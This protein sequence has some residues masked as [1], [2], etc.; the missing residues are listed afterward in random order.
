MG[1]RHCHRLR[2]ERDRLRRRV[3]RLEREWDVGDPSDV[4]D[5]PDYDRDDLEDDRGAGPDDYPSGL[6]EYEPS[7]HGVGYHPAYERYRADTSVQVNRGLLAGEGRTFGSDIARLA[8]SSQD[9]PD[10]DPIDRAMRAV[11]R[12]RKLHD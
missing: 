9:P 1:C 11:T 4:F 10:S 5:V 2:Q 3:E 8:M 7:T 12:F 6:P